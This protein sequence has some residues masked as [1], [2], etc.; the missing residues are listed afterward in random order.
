MYNRET[1]H[2]DELFKHLADYAP[3]PLAALAL[4]TPNVE[5]RDPLNT[6][7]VT[8]RT[9]HSDMTF[10]IY[11]PDKQEEAILH[12]EAQTD[13]SREKPMSLRILMYSSF[14]A[15]QHEKHVYSAVF[16]L[17]PPAGRTDAGYY[18]Y[19]DDVMGGVR[20]KYN[21]I[22]LY[23]LEGES[24]LDSGAIGLFPFTPL[25]RSPSGLTSQ[26][27]VETCIERTKAAPI[28]R[29]TRGTLLYALSV[30]GALV[31]P[32]ELFQAPA[33]EAIMQESPIYE[34]VIQR[35]IEQGIEQ[36]ERRASIE[37]TLAILTRQFPE[38]EVDT[39]KPILEAI[40]DI[41]R[42]KQLNLQASFI[43]TFQEFKQQIDA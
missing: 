25:M 18:E 4:N 42:L 10:N 6:E 39:L 31:H 38:A 2:F 13:E 24:F 14:L 32:P 23:E 27:W 34:R 3:N 15:H 35:G 30:F 9:H 5:V 43:E 21:V 20:L 33:L 36:G 16:Y 1:A 17:R 28:D 12:I 37:S 40:E 26:A 8:V 41:N 19:G 22:R 29:P 11:L 7:Q